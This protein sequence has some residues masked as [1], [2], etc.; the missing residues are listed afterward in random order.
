MIA[1]VLT[2]QTKVKMEGYLRSILT[3]LTHYYCKHSYSSQ[4]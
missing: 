1:E 3:V 4:S 2:L